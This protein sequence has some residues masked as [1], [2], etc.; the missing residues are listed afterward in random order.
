MEE[1]KVCAYMQFPDAIMN[2]TVLSS[3]HQ[4]SQGVC[5]HAV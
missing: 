5:I 2:C 1:C 4:G 3:L